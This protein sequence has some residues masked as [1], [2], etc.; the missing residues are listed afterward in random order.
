MDFSIRRKGVVLVF[1]VMLLGLLSTGCMT[2]REWAPPRPFEVRLSREA[3][4]AGDTIVVDV[5]G[6]SDSGKDK[7]VAAVDSGSYFSS[8]SSIRKEFIGTTPPL[9]RDFTFGPGT[10]Q[11]A[12]A[13][14]S[15]AR[16]DS[17]WKFWKRNEVRHL[18]VAANMRLLEQT[19]TKSDPRMIVIPYNKYKLSAAL[20]RSRLL[21]V[22]ATP[23]GLSASPPV[24]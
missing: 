22:K 11:M 15:L 24:E 3:V 18:V 16:R 4:F 12:R 21:E 2:R 13:S 17:I 5:I 19:Q 8:S 9:G 6:I 10:E 1:F 23:R 7:I 20:R 14:Q